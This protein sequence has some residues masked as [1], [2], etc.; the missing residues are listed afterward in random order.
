MQTQI[1]LPNKSHD[2]LEGERRGLVVVNTGD[3]NGKSTSAFSLALHA[4]CSGRAVKIFLFMNESGAD[5]GEQRLCEQLGIPIEGLG[6]NLSVK[7]RNL[8]R[9]IQL[10]RD[11]W[12]KAKPAILSGEYFMVLLDEITQPVICG[13]ISLDEV[14]ETMRTRP[15][16]VNVVFT[17][18]RCPNEIIELA[19]TVTEMKL[20]KNARLNGMPAQSGIDD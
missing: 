6:E 4:H 19:D 5:S 7:S 1:L 20:I 12:E 18:S 3:G 16:H 14:L 17:G 11:G 15:G 8:E 13:W 9:S 10:A 2:T